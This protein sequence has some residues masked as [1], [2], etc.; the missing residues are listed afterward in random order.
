MLAALKLST[1]Q[2][3]LLRR[4]GRTRQTM[5][6]IL[7]A[8]LFTRNAIPAQTPPATDGTSIPKSGKPFNAPPVAIVPLDQTI[9]GAALSV[10]GSMQAL[11]GRAFITGTG[12]ITAG[13]NTAEVTLPYR[14]TLRVCTSTTINIAADTSQPS[15]DTLPGLLMAMDHG[16]VE[17][18][19]ASTPRDANADTLMTPDFRIIINGSGASDVKV[20]LGTAG[21]TCIDNS[22]A[23]GPYVVVTSLFDSGAYRVQPGQ[24]VML[25]HGSL[26]EVVDQE[27][28]PCGCPPAPPAEA[29]IGNEFPL[30]Q[31]EGLAPTPPPAPAPKRTEGDTAQIVPPLVYSGGQ[32]Q[33]PPAVTPTEPQPAPAANAPATPQT[34]SEESKKKPGVMT[35]IGHF[36]RRVFGA[37]N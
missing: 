35:R 32:Q 36:F 33:S 11:N 29:A 7:F 21:D 22:G 8:A 31:S 3:L 19:F 18:S 9:R 30:A 27:K 6:L 2:S 15:G 28:E 17:M 10:S 16:A 20:R 23:A 1:D 34:P 25:Q 5:T 12:T 37:E 13:T 4:L 24:R 26:Q 14:G